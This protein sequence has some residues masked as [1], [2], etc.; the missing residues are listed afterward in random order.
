MR[1]CVFLAVVLL[2]ACGSPS[3]AKSDPNGAK[4]CDDVVQWRQ[5]SDGMERFGLAI[6]AGQYGHSAESADIKAAVTHYGQAVNAPDLDKL[7]AACE[8]HDVTIPNAV[9]VAP[10]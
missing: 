3:L 5:S 1:K 6:E 2:A 8:A 9:E 7:A 10:Q 4:A